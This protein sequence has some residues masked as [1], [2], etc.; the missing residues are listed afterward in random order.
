MQGYHVTAMRGH[1]VEQL[2][3]I[4]RW[5][6]SHSECAV[7]KSVQVVLGQVGTGKEVLVLIDLRL[8]ID[9]LGESQ[10]Q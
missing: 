1:L 9:Q 3:A 2:Q 6:V 7:S 5:E 8:V 10:R 4:F